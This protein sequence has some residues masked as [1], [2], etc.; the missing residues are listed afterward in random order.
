MVVQFLLLFYFL[1][2]RNAALTAS[3]VKIWSFMKEHYFL[4]LMLLVFYAM[5]YLAFTTSTSF[6]QF[7]AGFVESLS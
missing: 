1:H 5:T 4:S 7:T 6:G 3:V 2:N